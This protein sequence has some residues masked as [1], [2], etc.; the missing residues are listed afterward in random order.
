VREDHV[1]QDSSATDRDVVAV[2]R[3]QFPVQLTEASRA[4]GAL[5]LL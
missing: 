2:H 3:R 5:S 1:D 4:L